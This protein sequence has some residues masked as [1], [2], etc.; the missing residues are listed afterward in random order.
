MFTKT[1]LITEYLTSAAIEVVVMQK[2]N[3]SIQGWS[4]CSSNKELPEWFTDAPCKA[5][6]CVQHTKDFKLFHYLVMCDMKYI[7]FVLPITIIAHEIYHDMIIITICNLSPVWMIVELQMTQ[8][9]W[10]EYKLT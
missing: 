2:N 1:F 3:L 6:M 8:N 10:W 9:I 5:D 4:A 7:F